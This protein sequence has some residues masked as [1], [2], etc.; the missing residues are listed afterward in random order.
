MYVFQFT[1]ADFFVMRHRMA[2]ATHRHKIFNNVLALAP[3]P[4]VV[5]IHCLPVA[6]LT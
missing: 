2:S 4:D 5:N 1:L 6:A 3:P